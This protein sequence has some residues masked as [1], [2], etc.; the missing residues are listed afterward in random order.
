[1]KKPIVSIFTILL[2]SIIN[3]SAQ[4]ILFVDSSQSNVSFRGLSVVND[5]VFW[6]SGSKGT[7]GKSLDG[8]R[9]FTWLHP[10]GFEKRDFR[11]IEAFDANTAIA[12]AVDSP[13]IIIKTT[14]GG[15]TWKTVY[16]RHL[17]GIFLDAMSFKNN[18]RGVCV[19]DPINLRFWLVETNDGGDS[20]QEVPPPFRPTVDSGEACFASSGTNLQF[21]NDPRFEY[22]FVSGGAMSVLYLMGNGRTKRNAKIALEINHQLESTGANSWAVN[23]NKYIVVGGDFKD[24]KLELYNSA[25]SLDGGRSWQSPAYPPA[26]YKSCVIWKDDIN[27]IATGLAGTDISI[28]GPKEWEHIS[29][30]QFHVVQKAKKGNAIY[31]AGG[32]GRIG[33]YVE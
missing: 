13:A 19:G 29:D 11:D 30:I 8:G 16:E 25:Y 5:N 12:M 15:I 32:N 22:G 4:K 1:M 26:G 28:K 21:V 27:L 9:S 33:K 7:I 24:Y 10:T 31:L 20:W 6:V 14:D 3:L 2:L 17:H 23:G 18:L